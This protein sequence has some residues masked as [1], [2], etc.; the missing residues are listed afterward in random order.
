MN[1][2]EA[3]LMQEEE[4]VREIDMGFNF[5]LSVITSKINRR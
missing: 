2:W 3:M 1:Y 4:E 5:N